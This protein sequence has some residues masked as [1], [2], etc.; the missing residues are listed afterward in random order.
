MKLPEGVGAKSSSSAPWNLPAGTIQI[1]ATW[2][3]RQYTRT[4]GQGPGITTLQAASGF[5]AGPMI[6]F[7]CLGLTYS[8]SYGVS[9]E[10][11]TLDA[12]T[13]NSGVSIDGIDNN[14]AE[15]LTYVKH[16]QM[17][18]ITGT[19]LSLGI[20]GST[21][22]SNHSGPYSDISIAETGTGAFCINIQPAA[23]PRDIHGVNC[24]W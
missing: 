19:G 8:S 4:I 5:S 3:L 18:N 22:K 2:T 10:N 9:V 12:N 23:Q 15:E 6:Q 24:I 20:D 14:D 7:G 17:I 16:V 1:S 13:A 11:L 21:S